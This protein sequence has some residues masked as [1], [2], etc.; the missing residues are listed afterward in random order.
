M[1]ELGKNDEAIALLAGD[2]SIAADQLRADIHWRDKNYREA[3]KVL[4]RLA[5]EPLT[6]DR[7]DL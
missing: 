1:F 7:Y 5:G 6:K 4:Q 2:V 3:S